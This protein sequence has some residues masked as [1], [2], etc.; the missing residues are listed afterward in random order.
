MALMKKLAVLVFLL[1]SSFVLAGEKMSKEIEILSPSDGAK[2][3]LLHPLQRDWMTMPREKRVAK[4]GDV[5]G[6]RT[7]LEKTGTRPQPVRLSWRCKHPEGKDCAGTYT[8]EVMHR[9]SGRRHFFVENLRTNEVEITNLEVGESYTWCVWCG[10][11]AKGADFK[12]EDLAPRLLDWKDVAGNVRDLGG[13]KTKDGFRVRQGVAFRSAGLNDN[14]LTDLTAKETLALYEAGQLEAQFG[15]KGKE[16]ADLLAAGKIGPD[17]PRLRKTFGRKEFRKGRIHGT[18]ESREFV[19]KFFGIR[20][21]LDLRR[22]GSECWGMTGSPLG[23]EV[24]WCN[25]PGNCY[26]GLGEKKGKKK[27]RKDLELFLDRDNYGIVFHCIGGADRTGSLA[28]VINALLGVDE[29]DLW[30]DW[31]ATGFDTSRDSFTHAKCLDK[32]VS[33]FGK[34]EGATINERVENYVKSLGYKQE[35]IERLRDILIDRGGPYRDLRGLPLWHKA[36]GVKNL[37]D[38]GGWI[39]TDGKKVRTGRLF[40]S[41]AL[42]D[43]KSDGVEALVSKLGV[44][45]DLDLRR[46]EQ[47]AGLKGKSPLGA[48]VKLVN[49]SSFAY[50]G[51]DSDGGKECFAKTF[52]FLVNEAEYPVVMHCVKGADRTGSWAF[53]LNG[54]LGVP[55]ADLRYDWEV[56]HGANGNP[57][58]KHCSRY[59]R[60]LAVVEKRSGRTLAEKIVS[61]AKECGVT[62]GEIAK[63]RSMMLEGGEAAAVQPPSAACELKIGVLSDPH[64]S[65]TGDD[66]GL[67]ECLKGLQN[68]RVDVVVLAGDLADTG[69]VV[70]YERFHKLWMEVFGDMPGRNGT[71]ELV[72]VWGNHDYR[73]ASILRGKADDASIA[74]S[75][76]INH[77]DEVWRMLT[78]DPFP[79]EIYARTIKGFR[80]VATHWGHEK[81]IGSWLQQ[82]ADELSGTKPFFYVLHPPPPGT[83]F[84]DRAATEGTVS[85]VL[86]G[87]TNCFSISGHLH[88]NLA[89]DTAL[90]QGAFTAM[91]AGVTHNAVPR[92]GTGV[93]PYRNGC[94]KMAKA[95]P[96]YPH[97]G[98][99]PTMAGWHGSVVTVLD[100]RISVERVDFKTGQR[101]GDDWEIPLPLKAHPNEPFALS[102][103]AE[104]P[105]FDAGAVVSVVTEDGLNAAGET[106]RQ[107]V[108]SVPQAKPRAK[109]GRAIANEVELFAL[110]DGRTIVKAQALQPGQG[111]PIEESMAYPAKCVFGADEIPAGMKFGVRVTPI[112]AAGRRGRAIE[113]RE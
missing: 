74:D 93:G 73:R 77:K 45:T 56:T 94:F 78:G 47:V 110:D 27:L 104:A 5:K 88:A 109:W 46:P 22:S 15:K 9:R 62:D 76:M 95:K 101:I 17:D 97:M 11:H 112:N 75:L 69:L 54:L 80:F 113:W 30:R 28:F 98:T 16:I 8:V 102:A 103:S 84:T 4:F 37:R 100:G 55:E 106:E 18:E 35:D 58:F 86:R 51:F 36:G 7:K 87:Y 59:D 71:P 57:L 66:F 24:A 13:W 90:W 91:N 23:A 72:I 82:H 49:F 89:D 85:D 48:G 3:R 19:R 42:E 2:V 52:R 107:I 1:A 61:F 92:H 6:F 21:D 111:L 99:C 68:R 79:G 12:T 50:Q 70:E 10:K 26:D 83:V 44:K 65:V 64:L 40:R 34:Y 14:A 67:S 31:E 33:V 25:L 60:L 38:V 43:I 81:K 32:L 105:E 39:T 20:T 108:V 53:F 96:P 29:E 63:W 41:G